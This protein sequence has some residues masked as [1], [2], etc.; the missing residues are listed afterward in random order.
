MRRFAC[1]LFALSSLGLAPS[2]SAAPTALSP[3]LQPIGFLVGHWTAKEGHVENGTIAKGVSAFEP[4][5]G[6]AALLR[7]DRT[8]LSSPDGKPLQ[9][10]EQVM[11]IYPEAG[12][13]HADYFDGTHVIHYVSA[14]IDPGKSVTFD[15]ATTP[16]PPRFR[17]TYRAVTPSLLAVR[18]EMA[19]PGG[20]DFHT[21][22]EGE[23]V[24]D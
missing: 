7:R 19:P 16:G 1:L 10:F 13:L 5:A 3:T 2:A 18:F 4:A 8:D 23:A 12:A 6:G 20:A 17:L 14:A 24:R 9:S 15:T 11:L 21:I 22:A